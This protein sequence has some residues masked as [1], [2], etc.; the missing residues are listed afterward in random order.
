MLKLTSTISLCKL[1]T[2]ASL[3]T[4]TYT[5]YWSSAQCKLPPKMAANRGLLWDIFGSPCTPK[6][7]WLTMVVIDVH[8]LTGSSLLGCQAW[9]STSLWLCSCCTVSSCLDCPNLLVRPDRFCMNYE[10][11]TIA[12]GA[13]CKNVT[14]SFPDCSITDHVMAESSTC[15]SGQ[16]IRTTV[17]RMHL[18]ES[19]P[20]RLTPSMKIHC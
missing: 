14:T 2:L 16:Y 20:E 19:Y 9:R 12:G 17:Y 1:K 13:V 6:P 15:R 8:L 4:G 11:N 10:G 5:L 3:Y 18:A 7:V